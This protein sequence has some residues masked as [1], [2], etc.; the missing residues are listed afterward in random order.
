MICPLCNC[1]PCC[2]QSRHWNHLA[3]SGETLAKFDAFVKSLQ[4][5]PGLVSREEVDYFVEQLQEIHRNPDHTVTYISID[6]LG[7]RDAGVP[8]QYRGS[9][10][11][12]GR[13]L[14]PEAEYHPFGGMQ[15]P[16][17]H[18]QKYYF[19][20]DIVDRCIPRDPAWDAL[21][22]RM[23]RD[24][25]VQGFLNYPPREPR[26]LEDMPVAQ[27]TATV[28]KLIEE[29]RAN[30]AKL[31]QL[32]KLDYI[33]YGPNFARLH[34]DRSYMELYKELQR[35]N[36]SRP[37]YSLDQVLKLDVGGFQQ[38]L[39]DFHV[40]D[41]DGLPVERMHVD[42][43]RSRGIVVLSQ[44]ARQANMAL[45]YP[46][47]GGGFPKDGVPL[48]HSGEFLCKGLTAWDEELIY[49]KE[50]LGKSGLGVESLMN[51]LRAK[52]KR[53][54]THQFWVDKQRPS[55]AGGRGKKRGKR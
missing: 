27:L 18:G 38:R 16:N 37:D 28:K 21:L 46:V 31:G 12:A 8:F 29:R 13:T 55:W 6:S 20:R 47:L 53:Q 2:C 48:L 9:R 32:P 54:H 45:Q 1:S 26:R 39:V 4:K 40:V 17:R 19:P 35:T 22:G 5:N 25:L 24:P 7:G 10:Y 42:L 41:D 52:R 44:K 51:N 23:S 34:K 11:R 36:R 15:N 50:P 33:C 14:P 43:E 49:P 3:D 30:K